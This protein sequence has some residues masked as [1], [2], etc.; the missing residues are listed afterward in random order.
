HVYRRLH[1][2]KPS[3]TIIAAGGGGTWGLSPVVRFFWKVLW[4][5]TLATLAAGALL[6]L[7]SEPIIALLYEGQFTDQAWLLAAFAALYVLVYVGTILRFLIRTVERNRIIF[8]AGFISMVFSLA[9][10]TPMVNLFGIP[11][12]M[13]GLIAAQLIT[14]GCFLYALKHEIKL[15]WKSYT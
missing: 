13:A 2:D 8:Q 9:C 5:G 14:Q 7:F 15:L 6:A 4:Q 10:A 3:T 1:P 11:G 12:V